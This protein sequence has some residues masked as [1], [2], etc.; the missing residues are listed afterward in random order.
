M[1]EIQVDR[2]RFLDPSGIVVPG[3]GSPINVIDAVPPIKT[4]L[5]QNIPNPFNPATLIP[6]QLG[7]AEHVRLTVYST[8]GQE[9]RVLVDALQA[10]GR[11]E[12][13]WDGRDHSGREVASG[14]YLYRFQAGRFVDVRKAILLR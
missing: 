11:Y 5:L 2:V 13:T 8:L 3:V 6:Y 10:V 14:V 4:A 9:V 7:A 1:N 12:V